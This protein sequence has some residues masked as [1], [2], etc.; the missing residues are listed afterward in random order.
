MNPKREVMDRI[1]AHE[2]LRLAP[3]R[4]TNGYWTIGYG[5]KMQDVPGAPFGKITI[6]EAHVL[7]FEDFYRANDRYLP[8][9]RRHCPTLDLIRSGVCVELIFWVGF[10]GFLK[11][12]KMISA[13]ER[14]NYKR[15]A[16]ELYNSTLGKKHSARAE[17][18]A[19]LMWEG[20]A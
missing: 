1:K 10:R 15:A 16:L 14:E 2:G 20:G 13:I 5:H 11:F 17:S 18:L 3:Y 8:W 7:F 19:V 12:K 9:K 6:S 4:D